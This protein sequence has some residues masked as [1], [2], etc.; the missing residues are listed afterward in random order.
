MIPLSEVS[1]IRLSVIDRSAV[2]GQAPN[3]VLSPVLQRL[4]EVTADLHLEAEKHV[5]ILEP[6]ARPSEYVRYLRAMH[7]FHAPLEQM[8][9]G[10]H[11]LAEAGFDAGGR[12]R[13][14]DWM[15]RDLRSVG[16]CAE[17]RACESVPE[18]NTLSSAIGVA[19]VIEGSTLG[20]RFILSKLPPALA[21]LRGNAT[22]YL[23][24]Y[25][26]ETGAR[27]RAFA[28][29]VERSPV[30]LTIAESAACETFGKLIDWLQEAS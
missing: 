26:G 20:G 13:K 7:G 10:N 3:D 18:A 16:D 23:E 28:A 4:K 15:R 8:F 29:L 5:H 2:C 17:L 6:D 14:A 12:C 24:G 21:P 11:A 9:L 25:G 27:W 30:D 22:R 19:Y 1:A